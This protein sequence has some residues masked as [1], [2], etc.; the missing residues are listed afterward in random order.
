MVDWEHT[1]SK[2]HLRLTTGVLGDGTFSADKAHGTVLEAGG[3][4]FQ[5][6]TWLS[7]PPIAP[8]ASCTTGSLLVIARSEEAL[9]VKVPVK[10]ARFCPSGDIGSPQVLIGVPQTTLDD[11]QAQLQ[12][13]DA[14]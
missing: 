8:D 12:N 5:P 4:V 7:S 1:L 3:E 11:A 13:F 9:L 2:R 10:D 14:E 6:V